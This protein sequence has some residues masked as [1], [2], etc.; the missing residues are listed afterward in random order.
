MLI[1]CFSDS[2]GNIEALSRALKKH[3]S[4]ELILF[5]GD[6]LTDAE[7][8]ALNT[9]GKMWYAVRGNCDITSSF[10]SA[11]AKFTEQITLHGKRLVLTHGHMH[12][13]KSSLYGL[14]ELAGQT[15]ADAVI[16]GHTHTPTLEYRMVGDRPVYFFNPSTLKEDYFTKP[17]YG[18]I[19]IDDHGIK[20][21]HEALS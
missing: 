16:F 21:T 11:P 19:E 1:L 15:G 12:S 7:Y 10:M 13:A 2:H 5:L 6:G 18:L 3:P 4:A 17:T 9:E 14:M 8:A 20:F